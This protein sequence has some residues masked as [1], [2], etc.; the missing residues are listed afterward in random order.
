MQT[1]PR[2]LQGWKVMFRLAP[3]IR[4]RV[5]HFPLHCLDF[6]TPL[7]AILMWGAPFD[8]SNDSTSIPTHSPNANPV[9]DHPPL[10]KRP[11]DAVEG[12]SHP[13][14]SKKTKPSDPPARRS[15]RNAKSNTGDASSMSQ[16][17]MGGKKQRG[18][19]KWGG[20]YA[21]YD[22]ISG[23]VTDSEGNVLE[24]REKPIYDY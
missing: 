18:G 3:S 10:T 12:H 23:K 13:G 22:E 7:P 16:H 8:L 20:G 17:P 24:E 15:V 11:I 6:L 14:P 19:G 4:K 21:Y 5:R 9:L 2:I 1:R